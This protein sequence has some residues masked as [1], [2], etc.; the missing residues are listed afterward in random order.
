[1][2]NLYLG[3]YLASLPN[4]V[5]KLGIRKVLFSNPKYEEADNIKQKVVN[6]NDTANAN[7]IQYFGECINFIKG[8]EKVLIHCWCG[9]SR[10]ATIVIAYIMWK[11]K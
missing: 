6:I 1:M 4:N 7:I 11:K 2:N 10:S 3:N 8:D 9:V 5:K